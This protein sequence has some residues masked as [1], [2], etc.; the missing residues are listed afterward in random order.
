V[1]DF[2][3]LFHALY[4]SSFRRQFLIEGSELDH[5]LGEGLETIL[6]EST[7]FI[8]RRLAPARSPNDARMTPSNLPSGVTRNA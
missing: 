6:E 5:L 2:D 4:Q 1:R 3:Q 7:G 8:E